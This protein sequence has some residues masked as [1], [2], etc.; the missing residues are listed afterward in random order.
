M[1]DTRLTLLR[2]S[3][4][5]MKSFLALCLLCL[6]NWVSICAPASCIA[7]APVETQRQYLS[8]RDK[9]NTADWEFFCTGGRKSGTW[10]TI[11]VPSNWELL[12]FGEY[13][14]GGDRPKSCELGKYRH[15]FSIPADWKGRHVDI[16]FEGVMTDTEVLMN[17]ELVGPVHQGGFYRFAYDVTEMMLPGEEN[18][19]EVNVSKCSADRSVEA[20]ERQADYWVFGG[21]YRP[22]YLTSKP[23]QH[24]QRVAISAKHDGDF[25]ADVSLARR[26]APSRLTGR[27]IDS[28][29]NAFGQPF[30]VDVPAGAEAATL[31]AHAESPLTWTAETPHLYHLK[32]T[33]E[34]G[35]RTVHRVTE[36]FGFRTVEVRPGQGVFVNGSAVRLR[37]VNRHSF[38]PD[39]GRCLS[40]EVCRLDI[41]LMK[42]M[43]MN[44][45]RMS[46]YPPDSYF[47][48]LC[49][50]LGLYVID[51]LCTWQKPTLDTGVARRLVKELVERDVNHPS[52]L[53]WANGNEG[54]WNREVDGDY[55]KHDPQERVVLHPWD[56]FGGID[57]DHYEPYD[58]VLRKLSNGTLFM[59]TE[60]LHGLYDG[61]GGTGLDDYWRAMRGAPTGVGLFLWALLDEGVVRTDRGG[62]ID[63]R[64]NNAPD[65]VVGPYRE[66]EGSYHTIKQVWSPIRIEAITE[67]SELSSGNPIEFRIE[68]DY[69]FT[70]LD[71][72]R[73]K[74]E[75]V[76]LPQP[77]AT[78]DIGVLSQGEQPAPSVEPREVGTLVLPPLSTN[79]KAHAL[80]MIALDP[81]RRVIRS[82]AWELPPGASTT[83]QSQRR[84]ADSLRVEK[85]DRHFVIRSKRHRFR[86]SRDGGQLIDCE[87]DGS[88][89]GFGSGPQLVYASGGLGETAVPGRATLTE[90][91]EEDMVRITC[92]DAEG[93]FTSLT[94]QVSGD[95]ALTLQYE[96]QLSGEYDYHGITF[97]LA[98][99]HVSAVRWLGNGPYRVWKN[100]QQGGSLGVWE[101]YRSGEK[102]RWNY[103]E[104]K[105]YFGPIHWTQ[106]QLPT[107]TMTVDI[108]S[109]DVWLHNFTPTFPADARTATA[110]FPEGDVSFMHAISPMGTK[111][112]RADQL[113][114]SG[115]PNV[116]E[117]SYGATLSIRFSKVRGALSKP[118]SKG[119]DRVTAPAMQ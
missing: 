84:E 100:R 79:E 108:E 52:I 47:L 87:V 58:S 103:P 20:A 13:N 34:C 27:W 22:V 43:N 17:G 68:N 40:E 50:E 11:P 91:P 8:G 59:S 36:R 29:G 66:K 24:I 76:T 48:D 46:H 70:N 117:G 119:I 30:S 35:E 28:D 45:V 9:D 78:S 116:A 73:I 98:E 32:L 115:K 23:P 109:P 51:E 2:T 83:H 104:F 111:F 19:L 89:I 1:L 75:W 42:D 10:T 18:L 72:C 55:A 93:P 86:F 64:G 107:S 21:I 3:S 62:E 112:L 60:V 56:N 97:S 96:Y 90:H 71:K 95:G 77:G 118:V 65:G 5:A 14:W 6:S 15:R 38:W 63:V 101:S 69:D 39:S 88:A 49:D 102:L 54:G 113:G 67:K 85:D 53:F 99:E 37:G 110:A 16:V 114:P 57:T 82:W 106:W 92:L 31:S 80:R 74:W 25:H 41:E 61:G 4:A 94:W 7:E 26:D 44:A 105:G 33:L 81:G 12:G